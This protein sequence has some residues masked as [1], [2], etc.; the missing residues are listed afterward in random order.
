MAEG[1]SR[2]VE[3]GE[4]SKDKGSFELP[5]MYGGGAS[6]GAG[7]AGAKAGG[8][9]APPAKPP[10]PA[11]GAAKGKEAEDT[12]ALE[13]QAAQKEKDE[14]A[15]Q[16]NEEREKLRAELEADPRRKHPHMLLWLKTKIEIIDILYEQK[17]FE[18]CD[19]TIEVTRQECRVIKD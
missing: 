14:R 5:A 1:E 6:A 13:A 3:T 19:D 2:G 10:A 4:E 15:R 17:R 8:A 9:K 18:D 7:G 16:L 11:K 12:A